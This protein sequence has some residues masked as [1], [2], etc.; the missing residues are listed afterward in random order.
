[1]GFTTLTSGILSKDWTKDD[2]GSDGVSAL[3]AIFYWIG[4]I[5]GMVGV[6]SLVKQ[7]WGVSGVSTVTYIFAGLWVALVLLLLFIIMMAGI[8]G[9]EGLSGYW[10]LTPIALIPISLV[11]YSDWILGAIAGDLVGIP[12]GDIALVYWLY[13]AAK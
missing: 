1:M 12:S 3:W 11:R 9:G 7:N 10:V 4:L 13:F 8:A 5:I 6:I 2:D